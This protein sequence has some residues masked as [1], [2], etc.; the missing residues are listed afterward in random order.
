MGETNSPSFFF[1]GLEKGWLSRGSCEERRSKWGESITRGWK[2]A[3]HSSQTN[4]RQK[5]PT[6][7]RKG[8]DEWKLAPSLFGRHKIKELQQHLR[9]KRKRS[10]LFRCINLTRHILFIFTRKNV[11][12]LTKNNLTI[13]Y[14]SLVINRR[15]V[16]FVFQFL[17]CRK[18]RIVS[19]FVRL[20]KH[21]YFL[22]F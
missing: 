1:T 20:K 5:Y 22:K 13:L 18:N 6:E 8:D 16:F 2:S 21:L 10:P 15:L 7:R 9:R 3:W 12:S 14:I 11:S 17:S 19:D 4:P